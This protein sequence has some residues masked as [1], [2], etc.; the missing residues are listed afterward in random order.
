[1]FKIQQS[2][3]LFRPIDNVDYYLKLENHLSSLCTRMFSIRTRRSPKL[4]ERRGDT[5][6]VIETSWSMAPQKDDDVDDGYHHWDFSAKHFENLEY[7]NWIWVPFKIQTKPCC[8]FSQNWILD[9]GIAL[10]EI[11]LR[12]FVD[13]LILNKTYQRSLICL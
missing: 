5:M 8:M 1:M 7:G 10:R 13:Y 11:W 9:M 4:W 2:C 12:T 3:L 6:V